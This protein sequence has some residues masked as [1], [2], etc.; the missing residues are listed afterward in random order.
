DGNMDQATIEGRY[1]VQLADISSSTMYRLFANQFLFGIGALQLLE[2]RM[3]EYGTFSIHLTAGE[4]GSSRKGNLA[5]CQLASDLNAAL[6]QCF[7]RG[8]EIKQVALVPD[9]AGWVVLRGRT[10]YWAPDV[11]DGLVAGLSTYHRKGQEIKFVAFGPN[12]GWVILSE[13]NAYR[14]NGMPQGLCDRLLKYNRSGEEIKQVAVAPNFGWV[15][16]SDKN[17]YCVR[18]VPHEL[19]AELDQLNESGAEI[20]QV[21]FHP[22]GGWLVLH[23][24]N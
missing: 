3:P 10:G 11:P 18:G 20:K 24:R 22:N 8:E 9:R 12:H 15:V 17:A 13:H 5:T 16:L 14:S 19:T 21:A 1:E 7:D 6:Q 4:A 23:G 2:L